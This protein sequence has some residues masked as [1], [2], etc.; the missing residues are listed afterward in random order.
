MI[1]QKKNYVE[2]YGAL[3]SDVVIFVQAAIAKNS[4]VSGI[5]RDN[6]FASINN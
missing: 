4:N 1:K 2:V 5:Q 6:M 3:R